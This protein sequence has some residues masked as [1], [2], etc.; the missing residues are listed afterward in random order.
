ML[1]ALIKDNRVLVTPPAL[2]K[3]DIHITSQF[4]PN[5]HGEQEIIF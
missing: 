1:N 3:L 5:F 2:F 4:R